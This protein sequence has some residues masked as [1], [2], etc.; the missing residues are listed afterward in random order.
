MIKRK[1]EDEINFKDL[2]KNPLRL[3]GWIYPLFFL[4]LIVLG[5]MYVKN[6]RQISYNQQPVLLQDSIRVWQDIEEKKGG[7]LPAVDLTTLSNPSQDLIAAGKELYDANCQSCHGA[8]G[9]GDGAAGVALNPKPRN[10][11]ETEGWTNGRTFT[12]LYKTLQVGIIQNGMAAYE[13][14]APQNRVAIIQY[15]RTFA[16]YPAVTEEEIAQLDAEYKLSEGTETPNQIPVMKAISLIS[17]ETNQQ[18]INDLNVINYIDESGYKLFR[19]YA[20]DK[21]KIANAFKFDEVNS[22]D[23]F[24]KILQSDPVTLGFKAEVLTLNNGQMK[25]LFDFIYKITS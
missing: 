15:V 4:L 1:L 25:E 13:Y 16:D 14:I 3:F 23:N 8:D 18:I 6:L 9:K 12:D 24:V 22:F 11:H 5:V 19:E 7:I 2:I 21:I 17:S 20:V 10:F